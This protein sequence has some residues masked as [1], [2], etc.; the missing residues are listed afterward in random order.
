MEETQSKRALLEAGKEPK[1]VERFSQL[2]APTLSR[3]SGKSKTKAK[4]RVD[5]V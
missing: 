4:V 5:K 1:V 2:P 3:L